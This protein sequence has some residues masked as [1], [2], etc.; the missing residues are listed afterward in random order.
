[1]TTL[2]IFLL[3]V[4]GLW[5]LSSLSRRKRQ[6]A[7]IEGYRFPDKVAQQL[8]AKH[9]QLGDEEIDLVYRG[10]KDYFYICNKAGKKM[11][12]MPSQVVDDAW[13]EF[14]LFTRKYE[15]FCKKSLGRFLHHT[16]AE[17]MEST[18]QAQEG[19][20]RAWQYACAK[21]GI[22]AKDPYLLPLLFGIDKK[23]GIENGFYYS[24]DCKKDGSGYCAGHIG[25]GGGGSSC[26][27]DSGSSGCGGGCGGD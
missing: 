25:C 5:Y 24:L 12:S 14:I 19:I 17:A 9:P 23:L 22:D 2:I 3:C 20:K 11:V 1:M 7:F 8:K 21:E 18:T 4:I 6:L 27:G 16:P 10:L 13:H 26:G 15:Y